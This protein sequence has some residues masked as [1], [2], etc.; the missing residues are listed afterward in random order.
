MPSTA[1]LIRTETGNARLFHFIADAP[2]T[3][4]QRLKALTTGTVPAFI[5][6]CCLELSFELEEYS[7]SEAGNNFDGEEVLDDNLIGQI[8]S[9]GAK[10]ATLLGDDTW[11]KLFPRGAAHMHSTLYSYSS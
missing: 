2:T 11:T 7:G 10:N 3:T 5:G 4:F 9:G 6:Q 1:H 8:T